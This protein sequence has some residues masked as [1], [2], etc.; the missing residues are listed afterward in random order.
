M[1]AREGGQEI[2]G[3]GVV[4]AASVTLA[5]FVSGTIGSIIGGTVVASTGT[6]SD[7]NASGICESATSTLAG[8]ALASA[9]VM[10]SLRTTSTDFKPTNRVVA[11]ITVI[12]TSP[13]KPMPRISDGLRMIS[14]GPLR[15]RNRNRV[16][17]RSQFCRRTTIGRSGLLL[18][19]TGG[20]RLCSSCFR[21]R[22]I[23]Y[24]SF[25]QIMAIRHT[26][27]ASWQATRNSSTLFMP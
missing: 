3:T 19:S 12:P 17:W 5:S 11:L 4:A 21:T 10:D 22:G 13:T 18:R 15:V 8:G 24:P 7:G 16:S 25:C 1:A 27:V 6:S 23:T 14:T 2:D 20:E 9:V 26:L